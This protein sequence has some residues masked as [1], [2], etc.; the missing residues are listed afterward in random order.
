MK[1]GTFV[2][3][4]QDSDY[5]NDT[6]EVELDPFDPPVENPNSVEIIGYVVHNITPGYYK[7]EWEPG[8]WNY[9]EEDDLIIL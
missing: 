8:Y 7:V 3:L 2:Y 4:S 1:P 9:Y 5:F 6:E